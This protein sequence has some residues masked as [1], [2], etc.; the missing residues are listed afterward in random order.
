MRYVIISVLATCLSISGCKKAPAPV[1]PVAAAATPV[2][3]ATPPP[4]EQP[5]QQV[6]IDPSAQAIVL[7]YHRFEEHPKPKDTLAITP[8]EFVSQM[9]ALKDQGITVIPKEDLL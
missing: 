4:P 8:E 5:P 2:P 3:T 7:C 9:Q 1:A 6:A